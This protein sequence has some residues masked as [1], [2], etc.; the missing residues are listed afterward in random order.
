MSTRDDPQ[1]N[2]FPWYRR[3]R[4]EQPVAYDPR[5]GW[6]VFRYDDVQEVLTRYVAFSSQW[7][8]DGPPSASQ[9]FAASMLGSDPPRQR[10]LRSLVA[11]VF[12]PRAI[13]AL[14]P[15]ITAIVADL[16]DR[17]LPAASLEVIGALAAPLPIIV[18]AELLG[19]P[20][21][22]RA[23]FKLWSDA[24][25]SFAGDTALS[26]S[27]AQAAIVDYFLRIIAE[28][29]RAPGEDLISRLLAAEIA[30][31][32]LSNAELLGF[33]ALLLVAGNETTTNL[34]GNAML[35]LA[36][37]PAAWARLRADPALLPAAL[38]EVLRFRSPVQ[39]MFRV[40]RGEVD[41]GGQR[42]PA[43]ARVT[44]FIGSANH[45]ERHF[46]DP[47]TFDLDRQSNRHIAFGHGIHYCLGAP[48][49]RLEGRIALG[50][51]L[52]RVATLWRAPD[53]ALAAL[54][55]MI[56]YG[57]QELPLLVEPA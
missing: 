56:V 36:E 52:E 53:V 38:E 24:L 20:V 33:C 6:G 11:Q 49:A 47:A 40:A 4:E 41:L 50:A 30:G 54:P 57:V 19:I 34:I 51:L 10:Q 46:A 48:L 8:G 18:I 32:G 21:A 35:C 31:E 12:T 13:A 42:I 37:R 55:S 17:A 16:L 45:D 14:E 5:W 27:G 2:P 22:D 1:L 3:M 7:M 44:A 28:R 15:R 25:V 23:R 43:G 39:A 9:P 26:P 29:R